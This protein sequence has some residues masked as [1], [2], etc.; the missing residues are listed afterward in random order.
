MPKMTV[1]S[2][3]G[4]KLLL[5]EMQMK[6]IE[7][8]QRKKRQLAEQKQI[9]KETAVVRLPFPIARPTIACDGLV[10]C[11]L[12]RPAF[13]KCRKRCNGQS[14]NVQSKS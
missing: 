5:M 11:D 3:I 13:E 2:E 7:A 8:N 10:C 9:Q 12:T 1:L 14:N 6:E 4:R